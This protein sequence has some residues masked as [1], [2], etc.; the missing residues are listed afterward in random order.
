MKKNHSVFII[1]GII[2]LAAFLRLYDLGSAP[3]GLYPD[4]AMNGNNM[5]EAIETGRWSVFYPENNG[6]EGL[7][8]NI[9]GLFLKGFAALQGGMENF[10]PSP[11]MLRLPSA[12]FGTLT[13]L[14]LYFFLRELTQRKDIAGIGAF[15]LATSFWHINFSRI[16]FRAITAPFWLV[17]GLFFLLLAL[18]K[19]RESQKPALPLFL[20]ALAG[21][22]YG[23]GF[24]SYI[25]YRITP[26]LVGF[27][28]LRHFA[29]EKLQKKEKVFSTGVI[30]FAVTAF[31]TVMPLLLYFVQNPGSFMGRTSQVS[32]FSSPHPL[33]DL[34][35]NIGKTLAMFFVAGDYNWR[36]NIAGW[37][38]LFA[39]V[40]V[41][42]GWELIEGIRRFVKNFSAK[43]SFAHRIK[44]ALRDDESFSFLT[45]ALWLGILALPV[46]IS[47]EGIPHALRALP[48]APAAM[49][50]AAIAGARA[51]GW[52]RKKASPGKA[53]TAAVL[54]AAATAVFAFVS[55][56]VVF[57]KSP[58]ATG[59]FA[60]NY[61]DLG[62]EINSLPASAKKY[63]VVEAGGVDV[64]GVPMPAMTTMFITRS[65]TKHD[66]DARNIQYITNPAD[67]PAYPATDAHFFL[68]K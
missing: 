28:L 40:A 19:M 23:A 57:A 43:A 3:A 47:N 48:M 9:Q 32:V 33:Q 36:H 63:I 4:E 64:H 25:A 38:E 49:G 5:I 46:V 29:Q 21:V 13:V 12:L 42:F 50:I 66:R 17:W 53:V 35:L 67:I 51:L 62:K 41:L 20:F 30:L 14:G 24:H 58:Q 16:G 18:R 11:W 60:Q 68:L 55:Y 34:L 44:N 8:L 52:I 6:R 2:A 39:P 15:L 56:F 65:Y 10:L 31:L 22:V 45:L 37:P 26:L 54:F 61:V 1:A 59:A 27:I 7:F